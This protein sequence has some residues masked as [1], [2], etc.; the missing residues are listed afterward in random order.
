M[1]WCDYV[2]IFRQFTLNGVVAAPY[3]Y[4]THMH[5]LYILPM[6]SE[7]LISS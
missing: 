4:L 7:L 5:C 2:L 6:E 1:D 3:M